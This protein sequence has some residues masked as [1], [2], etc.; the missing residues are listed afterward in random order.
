MYKL[1]NTDRSYL[2]F[3][4]RPISYTWVAKLV[5]CNILY[6]LKNREKYLL[7]DILQGH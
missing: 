3:D 6:E 5:K 1:Y 4:I 2:R 7:Q